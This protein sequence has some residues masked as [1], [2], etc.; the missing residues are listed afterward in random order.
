MLNRII[1]LNSWR[2]HAFRS[3]SSLMQLEPRARPPA[4]AG[5]GFASPAS[6]SARPY[7]RR[8]QD[9]ARSPNQG[10]ELRKQRPRG[11]DENTLADV[12]EGE[13]LRELAVSRMGRD[14]PRYAGEFPS[15]ECDAAP[16]VEGTDCYQRTRVRRPLGYA[17]TDGIVMLSTAEEF[18]RK[19]SVTVFYD[20]R[21]LLVANPSRRPAPMWALESGH[22]NASKPRGSWEILEPDA[23]RA[24]VDILIK[25]VMDS[26]SPDSWRDTGG[27]VGSIRELLKGSSSLRCSPE[28]QKEVTQTL[29][30]PP[31]GT[32]SR[33]TTAPPSRSLASRKVRMIAGNPTARPNV[34][35]LAA[36]AAQRPGAGCCWPSACLNFARRG[37]SPLRQ[38]SIFRFV[39]FILTMCHAPTRWMW[40][41]S[42]R[43]RGWMS[44]GTPWAISAFTPMRQSMCAH[45]SRP[46]WDRRSMRYSPGRAPTV[47]AFCSN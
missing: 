33:R 37:R 23:R 38:F 26:V 40:C 32:L 1:K 46:R 6:Y 3:Q 21:D 43:V 45:S 39:T 27:T 25:Q 18:D 14:P 35:R 42:G 30:E 36:M 2:R 13:L 4:L 12:D 31:R 29:S 47:T 8:I 28:V 24:A 15:S 20:I 41:A 16:G 34:R 9:S 11:R 10:I 19:D 22:R 7:A 17:V 44:T 5:C